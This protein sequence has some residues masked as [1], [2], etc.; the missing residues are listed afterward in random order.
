MS[1]FGAGARHGLHGAVDES[2]TEEYQAEV[3]RHQFEMLGRIP[4]L[5]G[6]TPW[7]LKRTSAHRSGCSQASRTGSTGKG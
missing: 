4:F 2:W 5:A 3:Y 1:E 7:I 6:T